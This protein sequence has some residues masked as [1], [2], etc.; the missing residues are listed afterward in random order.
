MGDF[1]SIMGEGST[2]KVVGPFGLCKR[3]ER[4]DAHQLLQAT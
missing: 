3:N 1:N 2:D 4:Q